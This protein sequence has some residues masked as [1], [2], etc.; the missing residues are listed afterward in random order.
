MPAQIRLELLTEDRA[1]PRIDAE[2]FVAALDASLEILRELDQAVSGG[3]FR[4]YYTELGIG[5]GVSV[6]EGELPDLADLEAESM[7]SRQLETAFV[8]GMGEFER[9][10]GV[11]AGFTPRAV[12]AAFR[13]SSVVA[14]GVTNVRILTP[15]LGVAAVATLTERAIANIRE[16][17]GRGFT[18]LGSIEGRLETISLARRPTFNIRDEITGNSI[19]CAFPMDRLEEVRALLNH[20]VLVSGE[21]TYHRRGDPTEVSPIWELRALDEQE[22][23]TIEDVRGIAPDITEGLPAGVYVRRRFYGE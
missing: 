14:D 12:E 23:P 6:A 9:S 11:P 16:T 17:T 5:S 18:D 3:R 21:I 20:R 1:Q 7:L 8:S 15:A 22:P 19:I 13:L 4:W 10:P 2:S